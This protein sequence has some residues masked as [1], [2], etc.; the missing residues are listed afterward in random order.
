MVLYGLSLA[1]GP[2]GAHRSGWLLGWAGLGVWVAG[3]PGGH[4]LFRQASGA[5]DVEDVSDLV[6]LGWQDLVPLDE[7]P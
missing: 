3:Q 1:S 4:L 2:R 7:P 5:N 6:W